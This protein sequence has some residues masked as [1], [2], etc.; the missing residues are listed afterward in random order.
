MSFH[1]NY[2]KPNI[3]DSEL[4]ESRFTLRNQDLVYTD[5]AIPGLNLGLNSAEKESIVLKNRKLLLN[6]LGISDDKIAFA[7]QVHKTDIKYVTE[8]GVY[9]DT[10]GFV[11]DIPGLA[12]AIQVA[13]CASVLFADENNKIIGAAHAG[14]KGAANDIVPKTIHLMQQLG[15]DAK[16]I[17]AFISPCISLKNFEVG[18]EVASQFPEEFVE[19]LKYK[20][21]HVDLKRFIRHQMIQMGMLASNIELDK[22]C[23]IS[24]EQFYSYRRQKKKSGRMM[25]IITLK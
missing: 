3:F 2:I 24:E 18:E 15:A 12:L 21:P 7:R 11:T 14:W 4:V 10:D 17:K 25:G 9:A 23:T 13:D 22:S 16:N 1:I 5:S 8:G 19:R 6:D 20:K